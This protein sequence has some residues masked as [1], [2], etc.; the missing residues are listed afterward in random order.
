[1]TSQDVLSAGGRA[2]RNPPREMTSSPGQFPAIRPSSSRGPARVWWRDC[3]G[4]NCR[5]RR[6]ADQSTFSRWL[7]QWGGTIMHVH[8][9]S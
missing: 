8:K 6:R 5:L 9:G 1:M 3:P 7:S 4:D 2:G